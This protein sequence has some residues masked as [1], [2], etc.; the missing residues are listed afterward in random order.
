MVYHN[1]DHSDN[2][3]GTKFCRMCGAKLPEP[4]SQENAHKIVFGKTAV[5]NRKSGINY[6]Y[7]IVVFCAV[8]IFVVG[9]VVCYYLTVML[10]KQRAA[11]AQAIRAQTEANLRSSYKNFSGM[12]AVGLCQQAYD[13]YTIPDPIPTKGYDDFL[14]YCKNRGDNWSNI[15][16]E[17]IVFSGNTRADIA[18]SYD[19]AEPDLDSQSYQDCIKN[20]QLFVDPW[21]DTCSSNAS[22]KTEKRQLVETWLLENG[23]W[24]QDY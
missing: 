22:Q 14:A 18:S 13:Q 23:T 20:P 2:I 10:P 6:K 8:V 12:I 9:F 11:M 15:N 1:C 3:E 16:I 17:T 5:G 7:P 24:K 4:S 21:N 19:V